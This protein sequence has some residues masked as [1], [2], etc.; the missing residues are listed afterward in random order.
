[1]VKDKMINV[2]AEAL[3]EGV[4]ER[5]M[6]FWKDHHSLSIVFKKSHKGASVV[7]D[8]VAA[9]IEYRSKKETISSLTKKFFDVFR[10]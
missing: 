3:D 2:N 8:W 9:L 1:M 7:L 4:I 6:P 10:E 5:A